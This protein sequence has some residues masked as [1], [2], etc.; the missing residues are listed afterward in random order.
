MHKL[1]SDLMALCAGLLA[2]Q[3]D[4]GRELPAYVR[5]RGEAFTGRQPAIPGLLRLP[6]GYLMAWL[7]P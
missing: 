7:G 3:G 5:C 2:L 6:G 1:G 4:A